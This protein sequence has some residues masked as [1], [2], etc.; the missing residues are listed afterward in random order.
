[1]E[2]LVGH[3][4]TI[5]VVLAATYILFR[6]SVFGQRNNDRIAFL[7]TASTLVLFVISYFIRDV[8]PYIESTALVVVLIS[9]AWASL[10][11]PGPAYKVSVP[12]EKKTALAIELWSVGILSLIAAGIWQRV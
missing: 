5:L 12:K 3:E 6:L 8:V 1:M 9:V 10:L 11:L 7:V 2:Q 4:S